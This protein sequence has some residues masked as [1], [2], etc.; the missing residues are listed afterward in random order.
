MTARLHTVAETAS[1]ARD[2]KAAG[3]SVDEVAAIVN[4]IAADPTCGNDV[5]GSGGVRKV[6]IAGR[7]KGKSGGYRVMVA[8]LGDDVPVYLL[9]LLSKGERANFSAAEVAALRAMTMTIKASWQAR[10]R[11]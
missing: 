3:L 1:F 10:R 8:Y 2:A 6:R 11:A 7:S 9:A 4:A 5:Q